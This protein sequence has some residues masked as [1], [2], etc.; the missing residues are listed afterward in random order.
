[1]MQWVPP[2]VA[3]ELLRQLMEAKASSM[4]KDATFESRL[5]AHNVAD[6]IK[7]VLVQV[8]N[9]RYIVNDETLPF[10][11]AC[12]EILQ[13][14]LFTMPPPPPPPPPPHNTHN[15]TSRVIPLLLPTSEQV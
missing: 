11:T 4:P 3:E 9:E 1:M 13:T 2:S 5:F 12:L 6:A 15:V 8:Q 10:T 7:M 14:L